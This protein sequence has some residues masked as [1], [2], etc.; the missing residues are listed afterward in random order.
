MNAVRDA[1]FI[2]IRPQTNSIRHMHS[3]PAILRSSR[4]ANR[5]RFISKVFG[6]SAGLLGSLSTVQAAL[7]QQTAYNPSTSTWNVAA[8]WGNNAVTAENEYQT[9]AGNASDIG[10]SFTVNGYAW[11]YRGQVRDYPSANNTQSNS[12][13]AGGSL[14]LSGD[15]RLLMKGRAGYTSAAN[16][17]MRDDSHIILAPDSNGGNPASATLAG[18]IAVDDGAT[19]A[20]GLLSNTGSLTF[21]ISSTISGGSGSTLQL[22]LMGNNVNRIFVSGDYSG[23]TGTFYL[24]ISSTGSTA[25]LG[26]TFSFASG[27]A[28]LATLQL[29]PHAN[30][31]FDLDGD[32]TFGSVVVGEDT[33]EAGTYDYAAL[34][35][36]GFGSSFVDNGGSLTV[37]PEPSSVTLAFLASMA[38]LRRRR[39]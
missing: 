7:I 3:H 15:T 30:I 32:V 21:N 19:T 26:S 6:L 33:L 4:P 28:L 22:A 34:S 9:V 14:I 17:V 18:T 10:T 38:F 25:G 16:I 23:F 27:S 36:L 31:G 5:P 13:F 12:P 2:P 37:I 24:G 39:K 1:P 29:I 8:V 11:N 35:A 20:I